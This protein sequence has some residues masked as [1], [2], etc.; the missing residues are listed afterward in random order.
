MLG[1]RERKKAKT[2]NLIQEQALQLFREQ[3]YE[4]T[5]VDQIAEAA[6]VS[7]STLFRYFPTK[8]D[9]VLRDAFD[10][11]FFSAFRKQPA[12]LSP[13]RA[14]RAAFH[15]ALKQMSTE[16]VLE[17]ENLML[18]IPELRARMLDEFAGSIQTLNV[19]LAERVGG[20]ADD[21]AIQALSG[22]V[23]GVVIAAWFRPGDIKD[24]PD[25]VDQILGLLEAGFPL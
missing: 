3:G 21:I 5:T 22:A 4:E 10:P 19:L 1:L 16:D 13:I 7:L 9:L 20:S 11:A 12:E 25:R 2:R 17:R 14:L 23:V 18:T 24:L 15:E 8:E 6:E